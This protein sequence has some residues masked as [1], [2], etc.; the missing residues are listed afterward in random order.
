MNVIAI[1]GSPRK[2]WNAATLLQNALGGAQGFYA[3]WFSFGRY[4]VRL[5]GRSQS[6]KKLA[7]LLSQISYSY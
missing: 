4:R 6:V 2:T 7:L 5:C 1:N 3:E